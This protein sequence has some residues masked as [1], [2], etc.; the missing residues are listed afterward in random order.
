MRKFL[1]LK[2][3]RLVLGLVIA[4]Y[5]FTPRGVRAESPHPTPTISPPG[6]LDPDS[7]PVPCDDLGPL[8]SAPN[9]WTSGV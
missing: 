3:A 9:E 7:S 8:Q 2:M 6:C 4:G 1:G 5:V